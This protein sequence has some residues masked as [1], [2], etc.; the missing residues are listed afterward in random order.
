MLRLA[1]HRYGLLGSSTWSALGH[2]ARL[3]SRTTIGTFVINRQVIGLD[4]TGLIY[5]V[6]VNEKVL[7]LQG[8]AKSDIDNAF[9]DEH[10]FKG[11]IQ[12]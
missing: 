12:S 7:E 3:H 8:I 10:R 5:D 4:T 9:P 2:P 11:K 6:P 1:R